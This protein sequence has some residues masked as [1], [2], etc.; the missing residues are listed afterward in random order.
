M[1]DKLNE[2]LVTKAQETIPQ[3]TLMQ[4]QQLRLLIDDLIERAIEHL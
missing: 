3:L 2:E 1:N 4:L